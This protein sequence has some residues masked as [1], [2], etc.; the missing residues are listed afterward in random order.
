VK[1]ASGVTSASST[2]NLSTMI[3]LTLVA[4]SDM[5]YNIWLI[6]GCKNRVF[7]IK[8]TL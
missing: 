4:M 3:F 6:L 8:T 2:P 1:E 7:D 5:V